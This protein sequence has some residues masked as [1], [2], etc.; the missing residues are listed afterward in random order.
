[1]KDTIYK[2]RT[3]AKLSQER[4]AEIFSVSR[5][6]VQKWENGSATPELPK[7]I[8]IAKYFGIS[9]DYLVLSIDDRVAEELKYNKILQ[10]EYSSM[11]KWE[12]Y[13]NDVLIEYEQSVDE[14]LDV[15]KYKDLFVAVSKLPCNDIKKRA[16]DL[17][18]DIV[19]GAETVEGYEFNEPSDLAS[20][21][22]LR[23]EYE[24]TAKLPK[25]KADYSKIYG[26]WTGRICGCMLG[27]PVEGIRTDEFIPF[28]KETDNYPMHRYVYRTDVT[29][30]IAKKYTFPLQSKV[31]TDEIDCMPWD[32]DTNYVVLAMKIID[33]YGKDFTPHDVSRAWLAYQSKNSYCTAERVAYCNFIN[34]Y[35]P[36]QSAIYKNPF[37]EYIGAQ[38]RGDYFGYIYPADPEKAAECAWRDASISH[39]KNGIYGEMF[40]AAMLAVAAVTDDMKYIIRGGLAE[41]PYTS[42]LYKEVTHILNEYEKGATKEE[43]FAYIHSKYDEHTKY[44]WCH[45]VPNAMI[46]AASLLYGRGDFGKSVCMA[47]E[48]GFDTDCNGATV[49]SVFGMAY[50]IENIPDYWKK[51]FRDNLE[52]TI[53]GVGT[54]KISDMAKHT[55]EHIED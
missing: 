16:G 46:V 11:G 49:G 27:K 9:L 4:F 50:G 43:T 29:E 36:P 14:G 21:K 6:A 53:F 52:T 41:I 40:V 7:L 24:P 45:T 3:S 23:R 19:M 10:P 28:L 12:F 33:T 32:D 20:I 30:E 1:M 8:E 51:P 35:E 34:G 17:L 15:E 55:I 5:Q 22:A 38:I 39:V 18:F 42:R 31:Y 37:R 2:L 13:P 26:A 54:V 47:V 48:T 25:V 44:G